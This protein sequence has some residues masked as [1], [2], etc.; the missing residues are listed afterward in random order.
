MDTKRRILDAVY[1]QLVEAP[2]EPVSLD[3]VAKLAEVARSTI[4][5]VFGSRAGLFG[6]LGMDLLHR[7]GFTDMVH[8][9]L[10]PDA[11]Q[12]LRDGIRGNVHMYAAHRDALRTLFSMAE[13]DADAVGGA[14]Q[15]L[16]QGRAEGMNDLA[17]RLHEQHALRDGATVGY[18]A[19][20]LWLLT[21]FVSFDLLFTG[22]NLSVDAVT[23]NL[24]DTAE[25][26]LCRPLPEHS[27]AS[28]RALAVGPTPATVTQQSST[29][30]AAPVQ[31]VSEDAGV[32]GDERARRPNG[33]AAKE[34][35]KTFGHRMTIPRTDH[36]T[37]AGSREFDRIG[38]ETQR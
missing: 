7:G 9:V 10:Q 32:Q 2:S 15:R 30:V 25:H 20:V 13:L 4:Y 38:Q 22:R 23:A 37:T 17:R 26:A 11:R 3:K 18:A 21:S 19:D 16:E 29:T 36:L 8:A 35:W 27:S 34:T 5:T 28:H 31:P 12:G 14:V 6:A 33:K 1:Q 24:V